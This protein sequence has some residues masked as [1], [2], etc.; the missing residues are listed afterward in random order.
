[1]P[2]GD[3]ALPFGIQ[4][5]CPGFRRLGRGDLLSVV[6][7]E[8]AGRGGNV[9][10]AGIGQASERRQQGRGVFRRERRQLVFLLQ[11]GHVRDIGGAEH[12]AL[13]SV[14]FD[15]HQQPLERHL[16]GGANDR[17]GN[18]RIIL[19]KFARELLGPFGVELG[20]IP[21][22]GSFFPRRPFQRGKVRLRVAGLHCYDTQCAEAED[23]LAAVDRH[24]HK[25][26]PGSFNPATALPTNVCGSDGWKS[27]AC[28]NFPTQAV[29]DLATSSHVADALFSN[30]DR[31]HPS[32]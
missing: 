6:D 23:G 2:E 20:D 26:A 7:H 18:P 29:A 19:G 31:K 10:M 32:K 5:I 8:I 3:S 9:I 12:V 22:Q 11:D 14:V 27:C 4:Q 13:R 17:N 30:A 25:S 24:G 28:S 1:M 21:G 16:P 15:I